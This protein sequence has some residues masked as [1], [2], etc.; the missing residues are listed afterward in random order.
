MKR[1]AS[2]VKPDAADV[3]AFDPR[4]RQHA[5][6]LRPEG[7]HLAAA[8]YAHRHRLGPDYYA[9]ARALADEWLSRHSA[10]A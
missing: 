10:A 5:G 6:F 8:L 2:A 3:P 1:R 7:V 9:S 4:D